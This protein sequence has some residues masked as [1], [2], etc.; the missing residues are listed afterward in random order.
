M[1]RGIDQRL[2][3]L[4][5]AN[6]GPQRL[7]IV[8]SMTSDEADWDAQIADMI[9]SG[10]AALRMSS[11]ASAGWLMPLRGWSRTRMALGDSERDAGGYF[12]GC[13]GLAKYVRPHTSKT[14]YL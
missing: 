7:H 14:A 10:P 6:D 11:C 13:C 4:E 5:A 12:R 8:F 1:I 3:K 2:R 9:E